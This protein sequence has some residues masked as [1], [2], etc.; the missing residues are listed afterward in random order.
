M[1]PKPLY[2]LDQLHTMS[3]GNEEFVKKM[4]ELFFVVV[5]PSLEMLNQGFALQDYKILF[6]HAHKIKSNVRH[7]EILSILDD[8]VYIEFE[9]KEERNLEE[10]GKRLAKVNDVLIEVM[11]DLS[12]NL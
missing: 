9:S 10:I 3:G 2:S 4:I 6:S 8:I 11:D 12:K 5:K 7:F 1:S